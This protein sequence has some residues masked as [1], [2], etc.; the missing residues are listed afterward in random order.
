MIFH[1][2][3]LRRL[4][5]TNNYI[6]RLVPIV[7]CVLLLSACQT[8][9]KQSVLLNNPDLPTIKKDY[10]GNPYSNGQFIGPYATVKHGGESLWN[11]VSWKL[12]PNR[13]RGTVE[14]RSD[15]PVDLYN[16]LT[17]RDQPHI[18]WLGHATVLIHLQDTTI[19]VDPILNSPRL[20]H[21]KRLGDLPVTPGELAVDLILATHAHRDHLDK[22]TVANL[23]PQPMQA[24]V[25]LKMGHLLRSWRDDIDVIEGGWYQSLTTE[26]G[27]E[28][29][30]LPAMHWSRRSMFDTN[31]SL[32]G[33]FLISDGDTR[34][35]VAGDTGYGNH[36][37]EISNLFADIDFALLPIGSYEPAHI[38]QNSHM[39][40]EQAIAAYQDLN[41]ATMIPI[42]YGTYDLSD[43]PVDEP[44]AR[45]QAEMKRQLIASES[46]SILNIG[47]VLPLK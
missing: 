4:Q 35:F 13:P 41:A 11:Y 19:L 20:F 15:T 31:A 46:I 2:T 27:L 23:K 14:T 36:F 37:K 16:P 22:E 42:H 25:P 38:H 5:E 34:I 17:H 24:F 40:P 9:P 28:I 45:L 33:G 6:S 10:P 39:T 30:L 26:N 32:W 44:L 8:S 3:I 43:E 21:G 47:E 12:N 18:V 1:T 29:T 7:L